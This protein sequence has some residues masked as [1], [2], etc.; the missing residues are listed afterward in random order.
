M[1]FLRPKGLVGPGALEDSGPL[2]PS[3]DFTDH[4]APDVGRRGSLGERKAERRFEGDNGKHVAMGTMAQ[5]SIGAHVGLSTH[6]GNE[7]PAG[8]GSASCVSIRRYLTMGL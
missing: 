5:G 4:T 8:D 2:A 6:V 3:D 7:V 1:G